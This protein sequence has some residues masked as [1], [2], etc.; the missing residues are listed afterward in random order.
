MQKKNKQ[1]KLKTIKK[2]QQT[3]ALERKEVGSRTLIE[4]LDN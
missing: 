1:Q 2:T 3:I 4:N